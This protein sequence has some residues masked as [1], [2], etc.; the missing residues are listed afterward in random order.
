MDGRYVGN[1]AY[2]VQA[3]SGSAVDATNNWWGDPAGPGGGIADSVQ[4]TVT[5]SP[6]LSTDPAGVSVPPLG[7]PAGG[8]VADL[9][10]APIGSRSLI[11]AAPTTVRP[12]DDRA[13]RDAWRQ[14]RRAEGAAR[15]AER[16]AE[17]EQRKTARASARR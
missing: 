16:R 9:W 14:A 7:P 1:R 15:V 8:L 17:H 12:R 2:G 6:F 5:T 10:R 13:E 11:Q 3:G 4:G